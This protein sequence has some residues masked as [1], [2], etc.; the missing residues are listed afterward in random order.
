MAFLRTRKT[1]VWWHLTSF[2]V[3]QYLFTIEKGAG[4]MAQQV[5]V[6]ASCQPLASTTAS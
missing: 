6:L 2:M 1:F 3:S 5:E 4:E